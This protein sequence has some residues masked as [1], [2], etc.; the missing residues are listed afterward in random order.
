MTPAEIS[1]RDQQLDEEGHDENCSVYSDGPCSGPPVC[2]ASGGE[3]PRPP[4]KRSRTIQLASS[5]DAVT[6]TGPVAVA[7]RRWAAAMLQLRAYKAQYEQA[8]A[9]AQAAHNEYVRL[10]TG[11]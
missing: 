1:L 6:L 4:A 2:S 3:F 9:E 11:G 5:E 8:G 7:H 10:L